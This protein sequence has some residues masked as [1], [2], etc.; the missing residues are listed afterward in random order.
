MLRTQPPYRTGDSLTSDPLVRQV[1]STRQPSSGAILLEQARRQLEGQELVD[2]CLAVSGDGGGML[3]AFVGSF[4]QMAEQLGGQRQELEQ[5]QQ[6]LEHLSNERRETN[7]GLTLLSANSLLS[8]N[9][10]RVVGKRYEPETGS[11]SWDIHI[12]RVVARSRVRIGWLRGF[13]P[14]MRRYALE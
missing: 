13:G 2:R 9:L 11:G 4:N 1:M 10:Q 7:L 5:R 14:P 6:E 12:K 8:A 3:V